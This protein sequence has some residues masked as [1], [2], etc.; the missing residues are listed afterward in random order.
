M[1][2]RFLWRARGLVE[3]FRRRVRMWIVTPPTGPHILQEGPYHCW[4][5]GLARPR[6]LHD[7]TC[8]TT[9]AIKC[10]VS[11]CQNCECAPSTHPPPTKY[12]DAFTLV[13]SLEKSAWE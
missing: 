6:F 5:L 4:L 2:G 11:A 3:R 7:L 9:L 8:S 13:M 12:R 1:G 10:K